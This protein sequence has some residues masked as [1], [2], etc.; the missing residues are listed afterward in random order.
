M[1]LRSA[2]VA[3]AAR[4]FVKSKN[5]VFTMFN[6]LAELHSAIN[7]VQC[8]SYV[9]RWNSIR[10]STVLRYGGLP[11]IC[12]RSPLRAPHFCGFGAVRRQIE[13]QADSSS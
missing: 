4:P 7:L 5:C 11:K 10:P 2:A 13:N 6:R 1:K 9:G 8:C 3:Q 12:C